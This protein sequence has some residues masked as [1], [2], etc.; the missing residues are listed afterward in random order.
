MRYYIVSG[1]QRTAVDGLDGLAERVRLAYGPEAVIVWGPLGG[2]IRQ[3]ERL[4]A[5]YEAEKV[6]PEQSNLA[7]A[8]DWATRAPFLAAP[9]DLN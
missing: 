6:A 4:V 1:P 2:E 8:L 9:V 3:G 7:A 5:V